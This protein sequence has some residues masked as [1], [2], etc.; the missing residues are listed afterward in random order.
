MTI[1]YFE[2]ND[3]EISVG[4]FAER[5]K[6]EN[7]AKKVGSILGYDLHEVMDTDKY[8]D[9]SFGTD[10]VVIPSKYFSEDLFQLLDYGIFIYVVDA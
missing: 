4:I 2:D 10:T 9:M 6:P 3:A 5:S 8:S 1:Q 7:I